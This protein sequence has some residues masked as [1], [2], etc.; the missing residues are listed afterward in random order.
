MVVDTSWNLSISAKRRGYVFMM[1]NHAWGSWV[2]EINS[3]TVNA[4]GD[5]VE[6]HF[7]RGGQQ[8]ARGNGG[9][10]GGAFYLSHRREFLD[11]PGEWFWDEQEMVLYIATAANSSSTSSTS[12]STSSSAPTWASPTPPKTVVIPTV[13]ELFR[14]QGRSQA[15]PVKSIRFSGLTLRHTAPTY[16]ANYTVPSG[17][18]YAVHR[19]AAIHLVSRFSMVVVSKR[20]N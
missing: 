7:G 10:G 17:G 13:A 5:G 11:S 15:D 16:M 1:Q 19:G 18:D 14:V 8:E 20:T 2:Y 6:V 3:T 12:S 4:T 9:S